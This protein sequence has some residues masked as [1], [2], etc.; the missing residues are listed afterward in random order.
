VS[1]VRVPVTLVAICLAGAAGPAC[2]G[3]GGD[4]S[5]GASAEALAKVRASDYARAV[6]LHASDVPYF[7]PIPDEEEEDPE[8]ARRRDRELMRCV[9]IEEDPDPLAEVKSP[10]F[11]TDSPGELLRVASTV[12]VGTDAERAVREL[13]LIR[14][15]RAQRCL[16]RVYA[17]AIEEEQSSTTELSDVSVSR[18]S[19]PPGIE[20]AV[21]YRF[22]ASATVHRS[23]SELTAYRRAAE[24]DASVIV[25]VYV[26]FIGFLVGP[27]S[28][29]L[30]ATGAPTP[31]SRT[32]EHNLL[33][34]LHERATERSP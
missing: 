26:D 29:S 20:D 21:G 12:E 24:P 23:T 25:K 4:G 5:A 31:V 14:S 22:S 33:R 6:N 2:G 34:V 16:Q 3:D 32:L 30:T 28:V 27:A 7:E 8:E 17:S 15:R 18:L 10:E 9:G 11:G 1:R 19:P 13:R